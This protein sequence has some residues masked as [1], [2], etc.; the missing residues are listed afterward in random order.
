MRLKKKQLVKW[1][2][3][4]NGPKKNTAD[5]DAALATLPNTALKLKG[6]VKRSLGII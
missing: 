2:D 3:S 5:S 4:R 6:A 1:Q